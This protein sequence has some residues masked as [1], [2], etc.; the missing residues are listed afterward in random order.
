M[1]IIWEYTTIQRIYI[2]HELL[3]YKLVSTLEIVELRSQKSDFILL[4]MSVFSVGPFEKSIH[5]F[6]VPQQFS[7]HFVAIH[8]FWVC[9]ALV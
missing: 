8:H 7:V 4:L 5:H 1:H 3:L 2:P 6:S 9:P